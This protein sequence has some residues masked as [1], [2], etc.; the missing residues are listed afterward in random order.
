[1]LAECI[2]KFKKLI[3]LCPVRSVFEMLLWAFSILTVKGIRWS[4][5]LKS[6]KYGGI[7]NNHKK[8]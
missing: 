6:V 5:P 8:V 2:K 4:L 1:M 7:S 3:H